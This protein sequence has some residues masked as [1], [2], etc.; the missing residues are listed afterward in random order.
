MTDLAQQ[1]KALDRDAT[2]GRWGFTPVVPLAKNYFYLVGNRD[3]NNAE[4][5]L[6]SIGPSL[7]PSTEANAALIVL[8]RNNVPQILTAL[9]EVERMREALAAIKAIN[10]K[11]T[12][13][14]ALQDAAHAA[15][16]GK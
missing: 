2:A 15:I 14:E 10:P 9:S 1:I 11:L 3:G 12:S 16:G 7:A 6:G 8:L 4:V 5:D 13:I